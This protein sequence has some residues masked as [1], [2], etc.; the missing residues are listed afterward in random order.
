[1]ALERDENFNERDIRSEVIPPES[2]T[3]E[4]LGAAFESAYMDSTVMSYA[5]RSSI[6]DL[7]ARG[8]LLPSEEINAKYGINV[9]E[10]MSEM[11][12]IHV[13]DVQEEK[14]KRDFILN[15]G[16]DSFWSGT[17]PAFAAGAV[18]SMADPFDFG[19]SAF[20][21]VGMA[22]KGAS[23]GM[24]AAVSLVENS[25]ANAITEIG[26]VQASRMEGIEYTNEQ[27]L[28]NVLGGAVLMAGVNVGASSLGKLLGK[29][30][31][32][33]VEASYK[34]MDAGGQLH[35]EPSKTVD[36][37][38][39]I[40]VKELKVQPEMKVAAES[41]LGERY[42]SNLRELETAPEMLREIDSMY[43]A[44]QITEAEMIEFKELTEANGMDPKKWKL[45]EEDSKPDYNQESKDRVRETMEDPTNEK[46][47]NREAEK[48]VDEN[49]T[50]DETPK[51]EPD[52][53]LAILDE[54]L[55]GRELEFSKQLEKREGLNIKEEESFLEN[56][57]N[58]ASCV[59]GA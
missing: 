55:T 42:E 49:Q 35:V 30:G 3:S 22:A 14:R 26:A 57:K 37:V 31:S 58:Y 7:N 23:L 13:Q 46:G 12:A 10:P 47:Y 5:R 33:H 17:V 59:I 41:V 15:N 9:S 20:M 19:V 11:A 50:V 43:R 6:R 28:T 24:K 52:E 4:F 48:R 2:T 40:S 21:G 36:V 16:P 54:E 51:A 39:E 44:G 8:E 29:G 1:M 18:G 56:F 34:T 45:L 27:A 53:D 32:G 38:D 25:V